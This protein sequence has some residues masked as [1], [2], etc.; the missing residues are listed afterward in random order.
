MK[1]VLLTVLL[2]VAA[3]L[4]AVPGGTFYFE[5]R[6]GANCTSCH[7]MQPA[8]DDWRASSHRN[9]EC[10]KCHGNALTPDAAFHMRNAHRAWQHVRG[11][12]PE[13]VSLGNEHVMAITVECRAC[14]QQ[15][16]AK[17]QS[18]GHSA[19][20]ARIFMDRAHN[21]R[22][23]PMDDCLRCHGM[24]YEGGIRDLLQ[25][26]GRK[27]AWRLT[28]ATLAERSTMPCAT[29]HQMH[30]QG[31]P[32]HPLEKAVGRSLAT[33]EVLRANP[34]KQVAPPSLAFYDR[35]SQAY[36]PLADLP[37][38]AMRDGERTLKMSPDSRQALCYQCHA[39]TASMQV[40][41]GDDRTG[42]GVHEGISCL[43]CHDAHGR[44][45][46]APCATCHPKMS[47]CGLDVEKMDTTF[48]STGS[49]H[50]VHWVKCADCHA[51][52]VP[53][54]RSEPRP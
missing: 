37:I 6:R 1:R 24:F 26:N 15:E 28:D 47:N 38:P 35:R 16:Y 31:E 34:L 21:A 40:G 29:C 33:G 23:A 46:R 25:P 54:R 13:R 49:K 5:A 39:P 53:V 52:G 32:A 27:D 4:L 43:S 17:W 10:G 36:I 3:A 9:V 51:K 8:Y 18:G 50:N 11:E 44:T 12:A 7:E 41:S 42:A 19:H 20:Y 30:R 45:T 14:H 2:V 48:V 22:T